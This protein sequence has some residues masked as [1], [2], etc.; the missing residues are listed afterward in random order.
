MT[1]PERGKRRG[2]RIG[3]LWR[4]AQHRLAIWTAPDN[5]VLW[6]MPLEPMRFAAW[7]YR[8]GWRPKTEAKY[9]HHLKARQS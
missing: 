3:R 1:P 6:S 9:A 4:G 8:R 5:H 2:L 7:C